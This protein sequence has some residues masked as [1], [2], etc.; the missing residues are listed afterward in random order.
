MSSVSS[1]SQTFAFG[2]GLIALGSIFLVPSPGAGD[3]L[4]TVKGRLIETR[5]PWVVEGESLTYTDLEGQAQTMALDDVDLPGSEETTAMK[6]GRPYRPTP[7]TADHGPAGDA[8]VEAGREVTTPRVEP[9]VIL[10]QT[11]WCGYCRKARRLLKELDVKFTA[12]DIERSAKAARELRRKVGSYRGIPVLDI[13]G[14]IVRGYN[15]GRI[16]ELVHELQSQGP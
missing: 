10:Y 9:R 14:K 7:K 1:R 16:R 8:P 15:E 5:G 6:L 4:V 2:C 11:S 12:K 13:G 3:W